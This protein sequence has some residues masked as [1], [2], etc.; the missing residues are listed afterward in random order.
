MQNGNI[1]QG[2]DHETN[3]RP[4]RAIVK[5]A[6]Y[7]DENF[8]STYSCFFACGVDDEELY[9]YEEDN[10]AKE[11][12]HAMDE[13]MANLAKNETWDSVPKLEKVHLITCKCISKLKRKADANV[14]RFKAHS[15][16]P[17]E[18]LL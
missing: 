16:G 14:D 15:K 1:S 11:W 6:R 4:R 9:C 8:T 3:Q 10:D 5:P 18:A 7:R 13:G 17:F 12:R 2:D